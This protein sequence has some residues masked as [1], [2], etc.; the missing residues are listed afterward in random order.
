MS[1][2]VSEAPTRYTVEEVIDYSRVT[3]LRHRRLSIYLSICLTGKYPVESVALMNRIVHQAELGLLESEPSV[4]RG[5]PALSDP[6]E[7]MAYSVVQAATS[8]RANPRFTSIVVMQSSSPS[9]SSSS[10]LARLISKHRPH[11]PIV[12]I[13]S[14]YKSGRLL[15]VHKGIHPVLMLVDPDRVEVSQTLQYLRQLGVVKGSDLVLVVGQQ[16]PDSA[17]TVSLTSA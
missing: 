12:T 5:I 4:A 10:D 9:S 11:V 1:E 2:L 17:I 3:A 15:Q 6:L 14:D 7:A 16:S 8:H 13:V